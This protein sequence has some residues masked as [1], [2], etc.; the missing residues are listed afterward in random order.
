MTEALDKVEIEKYLTS[1]TAAV[2]E[3]HQ[4]AVPANIC[5]KLVERINAELPD[6][7][8]SVDN[9]KYVV[10]ATVQVSNFI[11][12]KMVVAIGSMNQNTGGREL[13][14]YSLVLLKGASS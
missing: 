4:K 12:H 13:N 11:I 7:C 1:A 10:H 8:P 3:Q 5:A 9:Y 6:K 14:I 2:I